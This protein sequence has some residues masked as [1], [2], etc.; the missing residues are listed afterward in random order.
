MA[1]VTKIKT[2]EPKTYQ[3]KVT[4]HILTLENGVQGYLNDKDSDTGLKAGSDV[5]YTLEVKKNKQ[6]KDY[7]LLTVKYPAQLDQ[8]TPTPAPKT[9]QTKPQNLPHAQVDV[10]KMKFESR[11]QLCKLVHDLMLAG[12][13]SDTEAKVHIT[14][15]VVIMDDLIDG[16]FA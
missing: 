5:S 9:E 16:I 15:W 3:G 10:I 6:G 7:N 8:P 2:I 12:K 1:T 14:D 11:M 4:G 13:F